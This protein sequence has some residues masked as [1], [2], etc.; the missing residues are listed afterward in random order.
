MMGVKSKTH[1]SGLGVGSKPMED[2]FRPVLDLMVLEHVQPKSDGDCL[3]GS[4]GLG[5]GQ[6]GRLNSWFSLEWVC[7][8]MFGIVSFKY[9]LELGLRKIQGAV[10]GI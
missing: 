3:F 8:G 1:K 4:Y 6:N 5:S 7:K 2:I 10:V 9:F